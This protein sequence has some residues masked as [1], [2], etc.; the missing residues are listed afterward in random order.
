M[1]LGAVVK[2]TGVNEQRLGEQV[3]YQYIASFSRPFIV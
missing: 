3:S 2:E 1:R